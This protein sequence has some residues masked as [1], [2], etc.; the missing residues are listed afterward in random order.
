MSEAFVKEDVAGDFFI[1]EKCFDS[2]YI[3]EKRTKTKLIEEAEKLMYKM[4]VSYREIYWNFLTSIVVFQISAGEAVMAPN[5]SPGTLGTRMKV[6][7]NAF[8]MG[9][10]SQKSY[11]RVC[12]CFHHSMVFNNH[13]FKMLK[14]LFIAI[15]RHAEVSY[16]YCRCV[17]EEN[18]TDRNN[19][20][21]HCTKFNLAFPLNSN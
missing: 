1:S 10:E 5:A 12:Y 16:Y 6:Q 20:F 4:S 13:F 21:L 19:Y 11:W 18:L 15:I 17:F 14:L 8:G 9:V 3:S 2:L 7:T